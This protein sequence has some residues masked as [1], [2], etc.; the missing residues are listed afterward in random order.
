LELSTVDEQENQLLNVDP[1]QNVIRIVEELKEDAAQRRRPLRTLFPAEPT[2]EDDLSEIDD[3]IDS[4]SAVA[5]LELEP[6]L[7]DKNQTEYKLQELLAYDDRQ[8]VYNAYRAVLKRP[9]DETGLSNAVDQLRRGSLDK[10]DILAA[11][12]FS[13]ERKEKG[14]RIP[15]LLSRA[16]ARRFVRVPVLGL[17]LA[18]IYHLF[19][20]PSLTRDQR[21]SNGAILSRQEMIARYV[22]HDV[23]DQ[24]RSVGNTVEK[25]IQLLEEQKKTQEVI[26]KRLSEL[27][28]YCEERLNEEAM[29]RRQGFKDR[30]HEIEDVRRVYNK[31]RTQVELTE[32][33]LKHQMEHL[34]RKHQEVKMELVLQ[35][36]RIGPHAEPSVTVTPEVHNNLASNN[37]SLDAFFAAFDEHF[38][39]DRQAVKQR[40]QQYLPIIK[41]HDA[42]TAEAPI[43]DVA[44]GRGEWLELLQEENLHASG[45]DINQ[46]LVDQCREKGL[47]A[48]HSE[49][50]S[51]LRNLVEQSVGAVSAFH[52]VE[53]LEIEALM[54]FLDQ[55]L[56]VLRPGGLLL[57]ETP[58]P[59]NVLVGSC[60]F[61]FDPTHRNPIPRPVLKFLV[62]SRGFVVIETFGLN[63]SDEKPV[64][65]DSEMAERFNEFFYGPMD[66]AIVAQKL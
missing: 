26:L 57:L 16:I 36:Q 46:V 20:L 51:H 31:Y 22:N 30:E 3:K 65:A 53:H 17:L 48:T 9:P 50:T 37:T 35:S 10:L 19:R 60:N 13:S 5:R 29:Q 38:R 6:P 7:S 1:R 52:I 34:F 47:A 27:S 18:P 32:K 62:E 28:T 59:E 56:R 41:K 15:G 64:P 2:V 61:Y 42:G 43:V 12:Y 54:S 66:Y 4:D 49:L 11:L 58:N 55:A 44:C 21:R 8:F 23:L 24:L 39:G 33:A 45:V 25:T 14:V 40:L 63:P